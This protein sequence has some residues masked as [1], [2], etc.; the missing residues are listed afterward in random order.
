M[1]THKEVLTHLGVARVAQSLG[2][3]YSTVA[4]WSQRDSI[5]ASYWI[6][7]LALTRYKVKLTAQDLAVMAAKQ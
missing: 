7:L 4:K 5:P 2:V 1:K 6:A 3:P